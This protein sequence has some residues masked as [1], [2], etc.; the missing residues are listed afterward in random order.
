MAGFEPTMA[1]SK[2]TALPLGDTP[3]IVF[4]QEG[5]RTPGTIVRSYVL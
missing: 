3:S 1:E 2:S 4:G 5:I